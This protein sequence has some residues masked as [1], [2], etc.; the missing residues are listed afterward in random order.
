MN[1]KSS[2]TAT[3]LVNHDKELILVKVLRSNENIFEDHPGSFK[4]LK[5][6]F[7][8][9]KMQRRF[10]GNYAAFPMRTLI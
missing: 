10:V 3:N 5:V 8:H 7:N 9:R 1:M 6:A 2:S 4:N